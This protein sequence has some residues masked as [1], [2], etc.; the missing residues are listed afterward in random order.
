MARASRGGRYATK[1][2]LA[3]SRYISDPIGLLAAQIVIYAVDDWRALIKQKAWLDA[4][5][6]RKHC[7]F[8][9][10]RQ[11]FRSDWCAFLMQNCENIE[12]TKLLQLL[13]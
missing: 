1:R 12:P 7:N 13:E 6:S 3:E 11:F 5:N 9:E 4:V 2:E 8:T 10:L